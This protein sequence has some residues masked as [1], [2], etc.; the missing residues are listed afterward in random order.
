MQIFSFLSYIS[1]LLGNWLIILLNDWT[2]N[3]LYL[4]W[5]KYKC[6]WIQWWGIL[7][8]WKKNLSLKSSMFSLFSS[9]AKLLTIFI[10]ESVDAWCTLN[11]I[12]VQIS[13]IIPTHITL[14]LEKEIHE[15]MESNRSSQS[16]SW[17]LEMA[18]D[19]G[20]VLKVF[21]VWWSRCNWTLSWMLLLKKLGGV[22]Y[23]QVILIIWK[24]C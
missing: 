21:K 4:W 6:R 9:L 7:H 24:E 13:P 12:V 10:F 3:N 22:N 1:S 11:T 16:I 23:M 14:T 19:T 15:H 2:C 5:I 8:R 17:G 20:Q 18:W